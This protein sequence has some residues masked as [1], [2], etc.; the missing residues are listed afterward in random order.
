[1]DKN[2]DIAMIRNNYILICDVMWDDDGIPKREKYHICKFKTKEERDKL[3]I[4]DACDSIT[5]TE[6]YDTFT[7]Y[8]N[9]SYL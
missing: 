4:G 6:S 7:S 8:H 9:V 5:K 3:Q 2:S 1:M